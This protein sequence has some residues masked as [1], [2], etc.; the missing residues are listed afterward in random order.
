MNDVYFLHV[1]ICISHSNF[2]KYCRMGKDLEQWFSTK[3]ILPSRGIW[4]WL[5]TF[6]VS[7]L[8]GVGLEWGWDMCYRH[9]VGRGR[10]CY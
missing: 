9:L 2:W 6:L 5:E 8:V 10:G 1:F 4:Q 3:M 7:K